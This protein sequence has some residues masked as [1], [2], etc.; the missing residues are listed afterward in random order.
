MK[1]AHI[2]EFDGLRAI[3]VTAVM[4]RHFW[5]EATPGFNSGM[6]GVQ[7]FF[8]LS[9]FLI[10]G[11]LLDSVSRIRDHGSSLKE[12]IRIFY[13]R[14]FLRIFPVYYLVVFVTALAGFDAVRDYFGWHAL[15]LTNFLVSELQRFPNPA[16]V[17][18]SLA[19]EEQFY[20]LWPAIVLLTPRRL[21][22]PMMVALIAAASLFRAALADQPPI[23][24]HTLLPANIDALIGGALL[25]YV[26]RKGFGRAWLSGLFVALSLACAFLLPQELIN[27]SG[28][29][30]G[31]SQTKL[32]MAVYGLLLVHV[33]AAWS[34]APF[35]AALRLAPVMYIGKI[36]Y[37]VYLYHMFV[38]YSFE[39]AGLPIPDP[40]GFAIK[41]SVTILIAA[42]SWRWFEQPINNLK[43]RFPY[44]AKARSA[45]GEN[46]GT[47]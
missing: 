37:G 1:S 6:F 12:E 46:L 16:G 15:Y 19:V 27:P 23:A 39:R 40:V 7:L 22:V 5:S 47:S 29:Q 44:A 14:R 11:I 35:L 8:V 30:A 3:A 18:W 32:A 42:A 28:T 36:S 43:K 38:G 33:A 2:D 34:G 17:F 25:V 26:H 24:Y 45:A 9:G 21:L 10:T 4:L 20:L 31:S 41:A 13:I